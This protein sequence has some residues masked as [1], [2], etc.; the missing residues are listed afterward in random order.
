MSEATFN[1]P[2]TVV[3]VHGAFAD[4]SS[5]DGVIEIFQAAGSQVTAVPNPL[6]GIFHDSAYVA[7]FMR[8][9]PGLVL[10]GIAYELGRLAGERAVGDRDPCDRRPRGSHV[11]SGWMP[12]TA[13]TTLPGR[14]GSTLRANASRADASGRRRWTGSQLPGVRE[15]RSRRQLVAVRLDDEV[16]AA[17]GRLLGHRD[18]SPAG[19]QHGKGATHALPGVRQHLG[20]R[21]RRR[22]VRTAAGGARR[23]VP[24]R[25][26]LCGGGVSY[27]ISEQ[28]VRQSVVPMAC[29]IAEMRVRSRKRA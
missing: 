2:L 10:G 17:V 4:S 7:S 11:P 12:A 13:N 3:L 8:Q 1:A 20:V 14:R 26:R 23:G 15:P 24:R 19:T 18:Q 28:L 27:S 25:V 21:L 22:V 16:H 5:W 29:T 9:I 6:R